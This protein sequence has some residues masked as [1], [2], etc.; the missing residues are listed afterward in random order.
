VSK[1]QVYA[2]DKGFGSKYQRGALSPGEPLRD[3]KP[4]RLWGVSR[5]RHVSFGTWWKDQ[6]AGIGSGI[7]SVWPTAIWSCTQASRRD[8]SPRDNPLARTEWCRWA[9]LV[10]LERTTAKT[11]GG[12]TP[13]RI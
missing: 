8:M 10:L 13:I 12:A 3:L 11:E 7:G 2:A 4:A 1:A 6:A 9:G 5:E